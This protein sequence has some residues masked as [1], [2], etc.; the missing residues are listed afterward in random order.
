MALAAVAGV[1]DN[2][3]G[4]GR[5]QAH[6]PRFASD[7]YRGVFNMCF[8]VFNNTKGCLIE[9]GNVSKLI[10]WFVARFAISCISLFADV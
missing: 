8:G 10:G 7:S 1:G 9:F 2:R 3:D 6:R 5:S 4:G